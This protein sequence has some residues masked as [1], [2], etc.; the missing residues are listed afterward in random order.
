MTSSPSRSHGSGESYVHSAPTGGAA[1][2]SWWL[3]VSHIILCFSCITFFLEHSLLSI[4]CFFPKPTISTHFVVVHVQLFVT[5]WTA[6]HQ[7]S[8]SFTISWSLLK[9]MS[10]K[11]VMPSNHLTL[12]HP[13][14]LLLSVFPSIRVFPN[15]LTLH[16]RWPKD[17]SFTSSINPSNEYSGLIFFRIDWSTHLTCLI[18]LHS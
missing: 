9:L 8:P 7:A 5:P 16:I 12:C 11:S 10:I 6:A 3:S 4:F 1:G 2:S 14:L 13:L 18:L 17:W 15:G